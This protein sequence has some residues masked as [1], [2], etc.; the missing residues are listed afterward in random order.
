MGGVEKKG[1]A[2]LMFYSETSGEKDICT[3]L[4]Y[5]FY[6]SIRRCIFLYM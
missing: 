3:Y 6:M 5:T 1:T 2:C 4:I